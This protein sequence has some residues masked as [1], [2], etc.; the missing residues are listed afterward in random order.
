MVHQLDPLRDSRWSGFVERHPRAHL[1]HSTSWLDALH[2]TYGYVPLV[3]TTSEPQEELKNGLLFCQIESWLTGRRLVSLPFSDHCEPLVDTR[4]EM[5]E[6]LLGVKEEVGRNRWRYAELR[7]LSEMDSLPEGFRQAS[8]YCLHMLDL[9]P[10]PD[11]LFRGFHKSCVQRRIR[12]AEKANLRYEHGRS[13]HLLLAFYRLM[14]MT[15][16]R[17][18]LPPQ[19]FAWFLNLVACLEDR[20]TIHLVSQNELPVAGI[21]NIRHKTTLVYKYGC[22]DRRF[23]ELGATPFVFWRAIQEARSS[24][25]RELD[26]GRSDWS[27]QGLIQFKDRWG[28]SSSAL[29]YWRFGA[30]SSSLGRTRSTTRHMRW[31]FSHLPD[32]LL[33]TSGKMLY[34]HFG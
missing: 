21:L 9:S 31:I 4:A 15:R 18:L 26:M 3:F 29:T 28:A 23:N 7:P 30:P 11:N 12:R 16:R 27:D 2:R 25:L 10:E 24:G 32:G 6:L 34:R 14:V 19:P 20:L 8:S 17:Q 13:D 1:F 5:Q 22:S 33:T